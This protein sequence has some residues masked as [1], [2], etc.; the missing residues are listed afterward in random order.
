MLTAAM[1]D[2]IATFPL[3]F[4]ATVTADGAPAVSPKGTFLVLDDTTIAY[5]DIRS[6]G[7][8]RNLMGNPAVEI[9]FIDPF[10]RKAVW[11]GGNAV[12]H[13]KGTDWFTQMH[14]KWHDAFGDLA[15][16]ISALVVINLDSAS[17]IW[18]PPYDD[19]VTEDEMIATYKARFGALYT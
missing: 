4:V 3:G 15:K 9:N 1:K 17:E 8:R 5:S 11:V 10:K 12:I 18:T 7:T 2:L 13:P 14:P 16:R 6:P 19:G